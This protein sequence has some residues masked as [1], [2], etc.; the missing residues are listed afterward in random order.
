M[1][2]SRSKLRAI[3]SM[4]GP[5]LQN[6]C[7]GHGGSSFVSLSK[8]RV[9]G[10][11]VGTVSSPSFAVRQNQL[12]AV[13]F[14]IGDPGEPIPAI[15]DNLGNVYTPCRTVP[16]KFVGLAVGNPFGTTVAT[17]WWFAIANANGNCTV[18]ATWAGAGTIFANLYVGVYQSF[19][20]VVPT[21]GNP[22][23][24]FADG[25][26][27]IFGNGTDEGAFGG[28]QLVLLSVQNDAVTP[29]RWLAP[30]KD[31]LGSAGFNGGAMEWGEVRAPVAGDLF[32]SNT[33]PSIGKYVNFGCS[34]G[35]SWLF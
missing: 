24:T 6:G 25:S 33:L 23:L 17:S 20:G 21:L 26:G 15:T 9:I 12:I 7:A 14:F 27:S 1:P 30:I 11:P 29:G 2:L 22:T 10:P 32:T 13:Q 28:N 18:T 16:S 31:R 3:Q 8:T 19:N 35:G 34:F 4:Y 5:Y